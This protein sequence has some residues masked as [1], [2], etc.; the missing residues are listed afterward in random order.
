[1]NILSGRPRAAILFI[2]L[3]A[4]VVKLSSPS[5]LCK[6]RGYRDV[7]G[8]CVCSGRYY[9]ENCEYLHCPFG[10]SWLAVP[11]EH[12]TRNAQFEECS[13]MG[14]CDMLSGICKCRDG[15]EGAAC[16]RIGCPMSSDNATFTTL[17]TG[18][19]VNEGGDGLG[20]VDGAGVPL[21]VPS[22]PRGAVCS[23]HGL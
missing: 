15:Y 4:I 7:D 8:S 17:P 3:F 14:H 16:E 9:G 20:F 19:Y 23:G 10:P 5:V 18:L 1:M 6:G 11:V 13:D 21:G 2:S 12:Y 22:I